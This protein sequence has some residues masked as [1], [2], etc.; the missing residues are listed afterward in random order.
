MPSAS[1][2]VGNAA[3]AT[4]VG[5]APSGVTGAAGS[6]TAVSTR[7]VGR[8]AAKM[9]VGAGATVGAVAGVVTS[10]GSVVLSLGG[11]TGGTRMATSVGWVDAGLVSSVDESTV[12]AGAV[13]RGAG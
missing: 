9:E 13:V 7:V 1:G 5:G 6:A 8:V 2:S 4:V 12:V 11:K 10:L 3:T